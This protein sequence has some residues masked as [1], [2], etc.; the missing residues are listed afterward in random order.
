MIFADNKYIYLCF[1]ETFFA[2]EIVRTWKSNIEGQ[3]E[4]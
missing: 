4:Q 2:N 3:N 1:L